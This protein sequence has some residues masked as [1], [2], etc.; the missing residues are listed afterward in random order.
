ML[1]ASVDEVTTGR[2]WLASDGR[3]RYYTVKDLLSTN[4]LP[5]PTLTQ[6]SMNRAQHKDQQENTIY[7][8][9]KTKRG[10]EAYRHR[11]LWT[12]ILLRYRHLE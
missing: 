8:R 10:R 7:E 5:S 11:D 6:I 3:R 1:K 4:A 12:E 9:R 2:V